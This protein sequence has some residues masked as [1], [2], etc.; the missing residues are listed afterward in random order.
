[1]TNDSVGKVA[2][3]TGTLYA[4]ENFKNEFPLK[5]DTNNYPKYCT[6]GV[7]SVD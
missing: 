2:Q 5:W 7:S 1:M 6:D 3:L 4:N